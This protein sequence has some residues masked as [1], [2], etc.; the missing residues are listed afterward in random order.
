MRA[1][2]NFDIKAICVFILHCCKYATNAEKSF[3]LYTTQNIYIYL[4]VNLRIK[5]QLGDVNSFE[6]YRDFLQSAP[7][8]VFGVLSLQSLKTLKRSLCLRITYAFFPIVK[9][10]IKFKILEKTIRG[11]GVG[12]GQGCDNFLS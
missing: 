2:T 12:I 9:V 8:I 1:N 3:I 10:I 7:N 5:T 4:V 6:S 11:N